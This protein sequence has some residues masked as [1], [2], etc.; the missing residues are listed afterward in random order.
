VTYARG[1]KD[2]RAL[3]LIQIGL[4][5]NNIG[6]IGR[7]VLIIVPFGL[8]DTKNLDTNN[9]HKAIPK[10]NNETTLCT[11]FYESSCIPNNSTII[12]G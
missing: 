3:H 7:K 11:D 6:K 4:L 1:S 9:A 8:V 2:R 10:K 12:C 5:D